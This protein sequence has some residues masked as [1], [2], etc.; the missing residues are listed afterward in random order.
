VDD[1]DN[2]M[3][4]TAIIQFSSILYVFTH[5]LNSPEANYKANTRKIKKQNIHTYRKKKIKQGNFGHVDNI[6]NSI[7]AI[8]LTS[9]R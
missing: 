5:L 6:K 8:T 4:E 1:F 7:S 9:M 3:F 2:Q